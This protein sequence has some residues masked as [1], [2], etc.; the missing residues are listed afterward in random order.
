MIP[1]GEKKIT[2]YFVDTKGGTA[3]TSQAFYTVL[4]RDEDI[5]FASDGGRIWCYQKENGEFHLLELPTKACITSMC[6]VSKEKT[7]IATDTDGFFFYDFKT[8]KS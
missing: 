8:G 2:S 3:K 4:E 5:C 6:T 7:V 1:S